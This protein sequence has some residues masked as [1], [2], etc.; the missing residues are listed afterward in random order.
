MAIDINDFYTQ[1]HQLKDYYRILGVQSN[2]S[3]E[4][5]KEAYRKKAKEVHPD[6]NGNS[7]VSER[8]SKVIN[9]AYEVLISDDKRQ[10]YDGERLKYLRTKQKRKELKSSG[11]DVSILSSDSSL[12]D[13]K[14]RAY[15]LQQ[16]ALRSQ[17]DLVQKNRTTSSDPD[18]EVYI[19]HALQ[20]QKTAL[21]KTQES[22]VA[23][24]TVDSKLTE[25]DRKLRELEQ[26]KRDLTAERKSS[27]SQK[28]VSHVAICLCSDGHIGFFEIQDFCSNIIK[29]LF[30]DKKYDSGIIYRER[31]TGLCGIELTHYGYGEYRKFAPAGTLVFDIK[32]DR[33]YVSNC[34]IDN[35]ILF[36]DLRLRLYNS[37]DIGPYKIG[38]A[39]DE[40]ILEMLR[41]AYNY[42]VMDQMGR[43]PYRK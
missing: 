1:S 10:A 7:P 5:I 28:D 42:F 39:T 2:A 29:D 23:Q 19:Q 36:D 30:R 12:E 14:Q 13:F 6:L 17:S 11:G 3:K 9:E 40:E 41:F 38:Q 21:R 31:A 8:K 34:Q 37:G 24:K 25:I 33:Y 43:N 35:M 27:E 32:T 26:L 15:Q 18:M 4:E 16:E 20:L 22:D